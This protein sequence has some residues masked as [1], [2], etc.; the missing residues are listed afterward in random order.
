MFD[1]NAAAKDEASVAILGDEM[2][3]I[4]NGHRQS[5]NLGLLKSVNGYIS[6]DKGAR[7]IDGLFFESEPAYTLF[8]PSFASGYPLLIKALCERCN[9][10]PSVFQHWEKIKRGHQW[11][12]WKKYD[13]NNVVLTGP[14]DDEAAKSMFY[15]GLWIEATRSVFL[16]RTLISDVMALPY[17]SKKYH[18]STKP[19]LVFET[20]AYIG[21][22]GIKNLYVYPT[23]HR[24]D[25]P[26]KNYTAK[27][28]IDG[29]GDKNYFA[30][31][32]AWTK[33]MGSPQYCHEDAQGLFCAWDFKDIRLSLSYSYD[34]P[35]KACSGEAALH[36]DNG[37]NYFECW[38][39][40]DYESNFMV[41]DHLPLPISYQVPMDWRNNPYVRPTP[42]GIMRSYVSNEK[43]YVIWIDE[44][45][46]K[47]GFANSMYAVVIPKSALK[48]VFVEV[49]IPDKGEELERLVANV[50]YM[51]DNFNIVLAMSYVDG[52]WS[53]K[54]EIASFLGMA[55]DQ[56]YI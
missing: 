17:V 25:V 42:D 44:W 38:Q 20:V 37:R 21:S 9:I 48:R 53:L 13:I 2:V 50:D 34:G 3:L 1:Q 11:L 52:I 36:I 22:V 45:N 28:L 19:T 8:V 12:I 6:D 10:S 7:K 24:L 14:T 35:S 56:I 41:K 15:N 16:W 55:I 51:D 18:A 43:P 33:L 27:I 31:K 54:N 47:I 40:D 26:A 49:W 23:D 39:D 32:Q 29:P 5:I 30:P 46:N 4:R